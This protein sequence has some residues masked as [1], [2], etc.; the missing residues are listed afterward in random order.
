MEL[1]FFLFSICI[2]IFTIWIFVFL[3]IYQ[4]ILF[5]LILKFNKS[6][7]N[8][9]LNSE[10]IA[11]TALLMDTSSLRWLK[12]WNYNLRERRF[13]GRELSLNRILPLW[14]IGCCVSWI[15]HGNSINS[16]SLPPDFLLLA[17]VSVKFSHVP[18][19]G[20]FVA[21]ALAE[22]DVNRICEL[23]AWFIDLILP[24][25]F[26]SV[27]NFMGTLT[28]CCRGWSLVPSRSCETVA[29]FWLLVFLWWKL[30][31]YG[32]CYAGAGIVILIFLS[33]FNF[34]VIWFGFSFEC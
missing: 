20:N 12:H 2:F 17:L 31:G 14:L 29:W 8:L 33:V 3:R 5:F 7:L 18:R 1:F 32:L 27:M 28:Y 11:L 9:Q 16:S 15:D 13:W 21:D 26:E 24:R 34:W 22:Q 23:V 19:E 25:L 4:L 10:H 30:C 6:P